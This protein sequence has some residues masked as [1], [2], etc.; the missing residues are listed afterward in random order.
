MSRSSPC[1]ALERL[2]D[3]FDPTEQECKEPLPSG[4]E[5]TFDYRMLPAYFERLVVYIL[6]ATPLYADHVAS[7]GSRA[8]LDIAYSAEHKA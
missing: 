7:R 8:P 4:G 5:A 2:A 1:G 6:G 3:E